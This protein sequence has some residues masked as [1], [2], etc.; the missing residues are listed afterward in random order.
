M[1]HCGSGLFPVDRGSARLRPVL[2]H[3]SL[4]AL[5]LALAPLSAAAAAPAIEGLWRTEDGSAVVEIAACGRQMCGHV[6]RVLAAGPN[7]PRTDVNNANPARRSRPL[8]GLPILWN[9][10]PGPKAWEHGRAYDPK[11]G[12]SYDASLRLNADGSLRV[13]GC[14]LFICQS[15]RWTR[16]R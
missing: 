7:V 15:V 11:S 1:V 16:S 12:K 3:R 9:F 2:V 10:D 13:T 6:A 4:L 8:V 14:V 5:G